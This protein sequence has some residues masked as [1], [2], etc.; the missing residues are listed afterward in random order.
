HPV[1]SYGPHTPLA[2]ANYYVPP[3]N[4]HRARAQR[5]PIAGHVGPFDQKRG[6]AAPSIS[7]KRR[8]AWSS[9]LAPWQ[10]RDSSVARQRS[11]GQ[12]NSG[13]PVVRT[14]GPS[15]LSN[16]TKRYSPASDRGA[17]AYCAN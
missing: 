16:Q 14:S 11:V 9:A 17:G 4:Y 8:T 12:T 15:R 6:R 5:S 2:P 1:A 3:A 10:G 13:Q 7:I